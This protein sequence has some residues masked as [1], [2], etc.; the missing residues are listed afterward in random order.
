MRTG[1]LSILQSNSNVDIN[2]DYDGGGSGSDE[3]FRVYHSNA[4]ANRL[5]TVLRD[6]KVGINTD[7]PLAL[8][9]ILNTD[10]GGAAASGALA[11][12]ESK[13]NA[14]LQLLGW[15]DSGFQNEIGILFG[16]NALED[17]S[18]MIYKVSGTYAGT[19]LFKVASTEMMAIGQFDVGILGK[20]WFTQIDKNEYI[21]SLA[22]GYMDYDATIGHRLRIGNNIEAMIAA[23]TYTFGRTTGGA[24]ATSFTLQT[25]QSNEISLNFYDGNSTG[26]I[27]YD[28]QNDFFEIKPN[29]TPIMELW[30]TDIGV[31]GKLWFTQADKN[32]FIDSLADGFLDIAATTAI[33]LGNGD[34]TNYM[35]ISGAGDVLFKGTSGLAYAN[36]YVR[37]NGSA[38]NITIAGT[39]VKFAYFDTNGESNNCTP[40]QAN[41]KITVTEPGEYLIIC[42]IHCE[43][44]GAGGADEFGFEVRVGGN[45]EN[46]L[47]A[48]RQM[49]G[50]GVDVGSVNMSGIVNIADNEAIEIY[51]TNEDTTDDVLIEDCSLSVIQIGGDGGA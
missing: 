47:H 5:L 28:G 44:T 17:Y 46:N 21:D 50:G 42:S 31:K 7:T 25:E 3:I 20:L 33:R 16:Y 13:S 38:T 8:C 37:G 9:H 43:S 40:D 35:Q 45:V 11:I 14:Y 2:G 27:R 49:A 15:D 36:V 41:N 1:F 39:Y 23:Q 12:L 22:D 34:V 6:S 30:P 51:C 29:N 19:I 26:T 32:E 4:P 48:H 18:S 10:T 24:G